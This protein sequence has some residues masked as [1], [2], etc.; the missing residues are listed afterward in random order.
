[1]TPLERGS[2]MYMR[3]VSLHTLFPP[4][5]ELPRPISTATEMF[6]MSDGDES[7]SDSDHMDDDDDDED[8]ESE[9]EEDGSPTYGFVS[10]SV[11]A[12]A[13]PYL[14]TRHAT[15]PRPVMRRA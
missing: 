2:E 3:P 12:H 4:R 14:P 5:S 11:D 13:I 1:M 8:D 7:S 15:P 6:D 10:V 9:F